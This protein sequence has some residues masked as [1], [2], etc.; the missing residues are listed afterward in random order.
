M[1]FSYN[2]G[3][4]RKIKFLFLHSFV[5][6]L[7]VLLLRLFPAIVDE[8]DEVLGVD[9]KR[10]KTSKTLLSQASSPLTMLRNFS[11][12][13]YSTLCSDDDH[14]DVVSPSVGCLRYFF[15]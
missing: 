13:S 1:Y 6:L 12:M 5:S 15:H 11:C 14:D 2:Q 4:Q 9:E 3:H 7:V 10:V 8:V